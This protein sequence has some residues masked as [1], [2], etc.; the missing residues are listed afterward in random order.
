MNSIT[1]EQ[2]EQKIKLNKD[3]PRK[4]KHWQVKKAEYERKLKRT[5]EQAEL[6][7]QIKLKTESTN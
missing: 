3:Q 4:L 6:I 1:I 7:A 2:I 5:Q